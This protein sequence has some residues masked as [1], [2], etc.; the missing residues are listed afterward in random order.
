MR[1]FAFCGHLQ[2]MHISAESMRVCLFNIHGSSGMQAPE[3]SSVR[4]FTRREDEE[5][6]QCR[7]FT[8]DEIRLMP[9]RHDGQEEAAARGV[10]VSI[11]SC[12]RAMIGSE[13][14][15]TTDSLAAA[16]RLAAH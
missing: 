16:S 7:E 3:M 9:W 15:R 12:S 11:R 4:V 13:E 5:P 14:D 8:M 10:F 1:I 2:E 6:D